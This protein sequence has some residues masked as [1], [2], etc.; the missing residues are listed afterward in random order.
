MVTDIRRNIQGLQN[1]YMPAQLKQTPPHSPT[2]WFVRMN[3]YNSENTS[4]KTAKFVDNIS[5]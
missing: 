3:S 4:A 5:Y 1:I 2:C